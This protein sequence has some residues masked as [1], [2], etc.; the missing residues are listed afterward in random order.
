MRLTGGSADEGCP[1]MVAAPSDEEEPKADSQDG[2]IPHLPWRGVAVGGA[3]IPSIE[4][5]STRSSRTEGSQDWERA[6]GALGGVG[7]QE[8]VPARTE[9]AEEE[10]QAGMAGQRTWC[11]M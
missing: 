3:T 2:R 1:G 8:N 10:A 5:P 6:E 7:P 9:A 11:I 4:T